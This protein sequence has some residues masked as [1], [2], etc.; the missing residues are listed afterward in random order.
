IREAKA[1]GAAVVGIFH[2][3]DVRDR[4]ADRLFTIEPRPPQEASR[5]AA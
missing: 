4:V 1:A 5:S 3:T 2:D